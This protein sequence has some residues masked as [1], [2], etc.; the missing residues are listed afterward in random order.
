[1]YSDW[2]NQLHQL[3]QTYT[4]YADHEKPNTKR[5]GQGIPWKT[6]DCIILGKNFVIVHKNKKDITI[7]FRVWPTP[8]NH[9]R[10]NLPT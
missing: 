8:E 1:M 6:R 4:Q 2:L 3:W 7:F 5:R 10:S 9:F